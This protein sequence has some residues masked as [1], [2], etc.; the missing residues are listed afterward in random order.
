M[1]K[2]WQSI[3]VDRRRAF[4][5]VQSAVFRSRRPDT[6]PDDE[7]SELDHHATIRD[8]NRPKQ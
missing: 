6:E 1:T 8:D 2:V 3:V 7:Q 5:D 4:V